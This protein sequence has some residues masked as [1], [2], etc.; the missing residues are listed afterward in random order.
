MV[1][2]VGVAGEAE[3]GGTARLDSTGEGVYFY[4]VCSKLSTNF[5]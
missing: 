5:V 1:G 3:D 2:Q 4:E